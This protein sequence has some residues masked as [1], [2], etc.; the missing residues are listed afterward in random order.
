MSSNDILI[1]GVSFTASSEPA[2]LTLVN[3]LPFK[4][5]C[6]ENG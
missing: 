2:A 3:F 1:G 6:K 4:T 5:F